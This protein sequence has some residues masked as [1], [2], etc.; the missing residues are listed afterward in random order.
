MS[1]NTKEFIEFLKKYQVIGLAI[2]VI[3]GGKLNELVGSLVN[4]LL[5]PLIFQPA[6]QAAHIDDIRALSFN[7]IKYGKVVGSFIDFAVVAFVI[8]LF[9]KF[10]LKETEVSKR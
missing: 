7:G 1:F 9:A 3:I 2:A 6:L 8:F 10:I 5:V 4:D